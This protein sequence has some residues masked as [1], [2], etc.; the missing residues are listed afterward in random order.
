MKKDEGFKEQQYIQR[1]QNLLSL[2]EQN[3]KLA[4]QYLDLSA[5]EQP[6]LLQKAAHQNFMKL[7]ST[8]RYQLYDLLRELKKSNEALAVRM[9]RLVAEIGGETA[10]E[11]LLYYSSWVYYDEFEYIRQ[12][13]T[14][15]QAAV[16]LA[17]AIAWQKGEL[18]GGYTRQLVE[19]GMED[20][21]IF[22]RMRSLCYNDEGNNT[23]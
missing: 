7:E 8:V 1:V 19:M 10:Q 6:A 18:Y 13:L 20:P 5:P 9:I 3:Q 4:A 23:T 2:T 11:I 17:N 16:I 21:E 14:K 22:C 12:Y 15:E